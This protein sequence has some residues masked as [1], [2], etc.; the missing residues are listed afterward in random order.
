MFH[1]PKN[2]KDEF[3]PQTP[4]RIPNIYS[5]TIYRSHLCRSF[6]IPSQWLEQTSIN[7]NDER[8]SKN[9]NTQE[10]D[11]VSVDDLTAKQ[12]FANYEGRNQPLVVRGA[13]N[14][15][16]VDRWKDWEYLIRKNSTTK[17]SFRST[18]GAAPLPGNFSLEAYRD[19]TT[20]TQYLEESPLYLFDRTAFATNQEWEEDFFPDF[21]TKC[22]YWDPSGDHGHDL[23]QHLG[24]KERPD[25]TWIIMGP[26]RSGSEFFCVA[27]V[28]F[29][30]TSDSSNYCC[31]QSNR[32]ESNRMGWMLTSTHCCF[33]F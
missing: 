26:K 15:K 10:V 19:Y 1:E 31:L 16:A 27:A 30:R 14:G 28:S 25:H 17:T 18:S 9:V 11:T 21:Y 8:T 22:P 3:R 4:M 32:I 13:A 7:D 2:Q 12:F 6:A 5:D 33:C 23:L 29:V 24:H 20:S